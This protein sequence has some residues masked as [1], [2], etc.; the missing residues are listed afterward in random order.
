MIKD[1]FLYLFQVPDLSYQR[2]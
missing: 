2:T 1:G